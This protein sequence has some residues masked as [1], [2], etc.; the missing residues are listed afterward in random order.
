MAFGS[1]LLIHTQ[2]LE[3]GHRHWEGGRKK[4]MVLGQLETGRA[5][6]SYSGAGR[7]LS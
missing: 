7:G 5:F 6:A 2:L 1:T 4:R 3:Q